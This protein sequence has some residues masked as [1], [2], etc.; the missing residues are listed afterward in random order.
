[1]SEKLMSLYHGNI[2]RLIV[3]AP[4]RSLKTSTCTSFFIP[5]LL[6]KDPSLQIML[7]T[8]SDEFAEQ[9]G[10]QIRSVMRHPEYKRLFDDTQLVNEKARSTR[11]RTMKGGK[12]TITSFHAT[13][14]GLGADYIIV[15]DPIQTNDVRSTTK[16][17]DTINR[18]KEGLYT[19][20]ND[21]K[22]GRILLV[23]QRF[24]LM[25]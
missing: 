1:M 5:W 7:V 3:N 2:K 9:L 13:M 10:S 25:I 18:F 11:L 20:L 19:R 8:Y 17:N 23:M 6:G 22:T 21:P 12:I 16:M 24:T 4:P 15:D 14:T